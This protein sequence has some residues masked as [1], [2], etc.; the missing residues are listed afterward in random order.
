MDQG[1]I[2]EVSINGL[3]VS[4]ID[5]Q[6]FG[7]SNPKGITFTPS[8]DPDIS[9]IFVADDGIDQVNDGR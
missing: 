6:S 1:V 9:H 8:G 3:L 7:V 5:L 4:M 2:Y